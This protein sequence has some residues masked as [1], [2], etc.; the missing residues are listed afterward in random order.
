VPEGFESLEA[1]AA[2]EDAALC[3]S[4]AGGGDVAGFVGS[5]TPSRTFL[6]RAGALGLFLLDVDLDEKGVRIARDSTPSS[7][8]ARA[9]AG[10]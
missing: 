10:S 7:A 5:A 1:L 3:V 2:R 6:E 9:S 8:A 4:G